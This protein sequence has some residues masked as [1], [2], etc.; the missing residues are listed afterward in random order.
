MLRTGSIWAELGLLG[1]SRGN[2][3]PAG[4]GAAPILYRMPGATPGTSDRSG[5]TQADNPSI[6][7]YVQDTGARGEAKC[8]SFPGIPG[9]APGQELLLELLLCWE[10][11]VRSGR[12]TGA[13]P[14]IANAP[15]AAPE[16]RGVL[17]RRQDDR[18][19]TSWT[20]SNSE[21]ARSCAAPVVAWR[22][23]RSRPRVVFPNVNEEER[24]ATRRTC[25]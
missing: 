25:K 4:I 13:A 1:G 8:R 11:L 21:A 5:P 16:S 7:R 18:F 12:R 15:G 24:R 17:A 10:Q 14:A 23:I 2:H 19:S 22:A 9:A 20:K 3:P 6:G